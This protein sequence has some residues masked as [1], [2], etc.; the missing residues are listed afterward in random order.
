MKET[1]QL[2]LDF[3]DISQGNVIKTISPDVSHLD[4]C[5]FVLNI[6]QESDG[7]FFITLLTLFDITKIVYFRFSS[8]NRQFWERIC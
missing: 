8:S 5:A 1:E 4:Y 2:M 3:K 7:F 6:T